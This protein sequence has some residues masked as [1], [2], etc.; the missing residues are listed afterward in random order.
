MSKE[1][2][3]FLVKAEY[4]SEVVVE[5]NVGD[6]YGYELVE[7]VVGADGVEVGEK[8]PMSSIKTTTKRILLTEDMRIGEEVV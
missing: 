3:T 4:G 7:C 1:L 5:G 6:F 8:I 2:E